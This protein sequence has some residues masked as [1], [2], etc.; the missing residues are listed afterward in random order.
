M[1]VLPLTTKAREPSPLTPLP[2]GE[3]DRALL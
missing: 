3:G 2:A 1:R